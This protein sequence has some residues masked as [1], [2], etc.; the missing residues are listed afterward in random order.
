MIT[1]EQLLQEQSRHNSRLQELRI[2]IAEY[3]KYQQSP[4]YTN[5]RYSACNAIAQREVAFLEAEANHTD[6]KL[7][8][9][10]AALAE[11][12]RLAQR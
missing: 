9:T 2:E 6:T 5:P 12:R 8:N 4:D 10:N 3:R 7:R 11:A 1:P